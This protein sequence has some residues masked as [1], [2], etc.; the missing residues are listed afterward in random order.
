MKVENARLCGKVFSV[1]V[2]GDTFAVT[3][4]GGETKRAAVGE[5]IKI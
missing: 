1:D 3:V 2:T 4:D 5:T